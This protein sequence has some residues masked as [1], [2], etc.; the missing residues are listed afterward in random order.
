MDE[1]LANLE[2]DI[3]SGEYEIVNKVLQ[4]HYSER[5]YHT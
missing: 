5:S 4:F 2:T 3:I 1:M